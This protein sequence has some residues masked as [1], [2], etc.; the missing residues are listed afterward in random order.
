[1]LFFMFRGRRVQALGE[2]DT[3]LLRDFENQ[4]G[5]P[6]FDGTLKQGLSVDLAQSPFSECAF[7]QEDS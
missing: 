6:V 2:R 4:T 3:V 1:M 5:D 7:D